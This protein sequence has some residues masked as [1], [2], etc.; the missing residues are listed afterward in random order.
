ML[1][2]IDPSNGLPI[3]DQIS[4]QVKFAIAHGVL[5][6]GELVPSVRELA[7]QVAVNPNTV[8]RAYRDLQS[9]G[10]L[11]TLRGE[12]LRVTQGALETCRRDRQTLLKSRLRSAIAECRQSGLK[13]GEIRSLIDDVLRDTVEAATS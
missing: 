4:R 8:A 12:G 11:E 7:Q 9:D 3:Y 10:V 13:T 5:R 6:A 2:H 1:L